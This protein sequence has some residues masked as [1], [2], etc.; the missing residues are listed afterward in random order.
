MK[1]LITSLAAA[2]LFALIIGISAAEP[3][4]HMSSEVAYTGFINK[5]DYDK[6]YDWAVM[7]KDFD[8]ADN[9]LAQLLI[10][11][12]AT[13]FEKGEAV[14]VEDNGLFGLSD[15]QVRRQGETI[16]YWTFPEAAECPRL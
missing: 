16:L 8:A 11:G 5:E 2:I 13:I 6:F 14:Y 4:C 15:M 9:F 10:L 7:D 1:A 12:T 3:L